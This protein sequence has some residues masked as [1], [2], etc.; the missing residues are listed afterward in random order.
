MSANLVNHGVIGLT[1]TPGT[2]EHFSKITVGYPLIYPIAASLAIFGNNILVARA[3]MAL[4]LLMVLLVA[5]FL[6]RKS[7][8][9]NEALLS[10]ALLVSFAP[11]YGNGKSVLGEVPGILY[12]LLSLLLMHLARVNKE[13][14]KSNYFL[15]LSGFF[16]GL[17]VTTKPIFILFIGALMF[18]FLFKRKDILCFGKK[19][20]LFP[21]FFAISFVL[22]I[23]TQFQSGDS[24][25][26]ILA[27]YVNP[28]N[29][30]SLSSTIMTNIGMFFGQ[31][32]SVYLLAL[33]II[34]SFS[35]IIRTKEQKPGFEEITSFIFS[36][37]V[38]AAFFRTSGYL[39]YLFPA[40]VLSIIYF[41]GSLYYCFGFIRAKMERYS[42]IHKIFSRKSAI[43]LVVILFIFGTYQLMFNS[44]VADSYGSRKTAFWYNYFSTLPTDEKIFFY[45]TPEVA[46]FIKNGNYYQ[47]L[48]LSPAGLF[49][50]K[51]NNSLID[52]GGVDQVIL[53]TDTFQNNKDK[54]ETHY[55]LEREAFKY[56]ILVKK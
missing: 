1:V 32:G 3:T 51:D 56:T 27:F 48:D 5:Y 34:W 41:P 25:A 30:G 10:L 2:V 46:M 23:F 13:Q 8:G 20:F 43:I 53:K 26:Q 54:W 31:I 52:E 19:V 35:I 6:V 18:T 39:R 50:G 36:L 38:T 37:L 12:L 33:L 15:A 55:R 40:Q 24:P 29:V 21:I 45:D 44:W 9:K 42:L 4:F 28:Q 22:W 47:Y 17:C 11:L 16:A 14:G 49:V 7:I